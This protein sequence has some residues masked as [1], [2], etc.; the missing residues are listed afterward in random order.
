MSGADTEH[1]HRCRA[2]HRWQHTGP[3]ALT[4]SI[5]VPDSGD[6]ALV[7]AEDCPLCSGREELL[8]REIHTHYC[9][10]CGG[11]WD[12]EGRCLDGPVACCPWCF[13]AEGSSPAPGAR[14]GSHFHF[15]PECKLNWQ[16][17]TSCSAPLRV[18]L[19]DCPGC[20][21]P[22][23]VPST[24]DR[25]PEPTPGFWPSRAR[26]SCSDIV[27]AGAGFI[28]PAV[29]PAGIAAGTMLVIAII[30]KVTMTDLAPQRAV[31]PPQAPAGPAQ[32]A[33]PSEPIG[34]PPGQ[35]ATSS[36]APAQL[37]QEGERREEPGTPTAPPARPAQTKALARF[38]PGTPPR[39]GA[40]L[41]T[42]LQSPPRRAG[43]SKRRE[44]LP[45]WSAESPRWD[46]ASIS[47]LM[48]AV[49][50][51]RPQRIG[52]V[53]AQAPAR[54]GREPREPEPRPSRG[55]VVDELGH[56]F[57]SHK[58]LGGGTSIEVVLFDGRTF[59]A[60]VV[61]R[62]PLNDVAVLRLER[63]GLPIIALGDSTALAI[64]DRVL[65]L[66]NGVGPDTTPTA[67]TVLAT[68]AGT[69]GNLAVDL[70]PKPDS[71][72][73][74]LLNHL[75]QAVGIVTDAASS[76]GSPPEFTVAV[77]VDRV[78]WLLRNVSPRPTAESTSTR[79]SP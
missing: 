44:D 13:P 33:R 43:S 22:R 27:R 2:G 52:S 8:T 71:I 11:D 5:P 36:P 75:G 63:R 7:G 42:V 48:Q 15:C 78:K 41:D 79:Q 12:H 35:P 1:P 76:T 58:R 55:F 28:R 34:D 45:T 18:A 72:G 67:A 73:T 59:G 39:G 50:D 69:G 77:P 9:N 24:G 65:A 40:A 51:V 23:A 46:R 16:H 66:G 4:C 6:L 32:L 21:K 61:A 30:L 37:R 47:A 38:I 53:P 54:A 14:Q 20:G 74:P 10:I 49:V 31:A 56:I 25:A 60:T 19:P 17:D 68:G 57:T 64:G 26:A 29:V 70:M 3:T 62:N